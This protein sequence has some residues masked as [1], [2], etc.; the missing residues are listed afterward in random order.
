[1]FS[2]ANEKVDVLA[3]IPNPVLSVRLRPE[4]CRSFFDLTFELSA[5]YPNEAPKVKISSDDYSR[6][7][8][9]LLTE[10]ITEEAK[11]SMVLGNFKA[12]YEFTLPGD[13]RKDWGIGILFGVV[14][15]SI[16]YLV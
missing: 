13:E 9:D 2:A 10:K 16:Y 3:K 11:N 4:G 5:A 7:K 14:K 12:L 15:F 6:Q 8:T 1:M